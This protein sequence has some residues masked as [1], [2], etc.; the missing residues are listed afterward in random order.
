MERNLLI[1]DDSMGL[2]LRK[3]KAAQQ[4]C[5]GTRCVHRCKP[6]VVAIAVYAR[7]LTMGALSSTD[8]S[9]CKTG[10]F[11]NETDIYDCGAVHYDVPDS[12]S[13]SSGQC[14]LKT[15]FDLRN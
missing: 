2:V 9:S 5:L 10:L 4:L 11:D 14:E 8:K 7:T 6:S 15:R 1:L 13:K 3:K 12:V